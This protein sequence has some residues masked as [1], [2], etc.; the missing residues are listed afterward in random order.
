MPAWPAA[1]AEAEE[2]EGM[3][4]RSGELEAAEAMAELAVA[5]DNRRDVISAVT[6]EGDWAPAMCTSVR[7]RRRVECDKKKTK[8]MS[9]T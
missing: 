5:D 3:C 9:C 8:E 7:L 2:D 4:G 1:E 6:E